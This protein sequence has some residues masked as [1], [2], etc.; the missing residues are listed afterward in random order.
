MKNCTCK[1][2]NRKVA[3]KNYKLNVTAKNKTLTNQKLKTIKMV[4]TEQA[5]N[6][7]HKPENTYLKFLTLLTLLTQSVK[8]IVNLIVS[9][10]F[11]KEEI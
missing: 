7:T 5:T 4:K 1:G 10:K 11:I 3:I 9:S 6:T 8:K 2:S